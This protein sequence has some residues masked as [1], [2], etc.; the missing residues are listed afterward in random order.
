MA[1][2]ERLVAFAPN[3]RGDGA[4]AVDRKGNI[5]AF[6]TAPEFREVPEPVPWRGGPFVAI[7]STPSG[8]G[9]WILDSKGNLLAYGDATE[10]RS[11][12][13]SDDKSGR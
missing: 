2:R 8:Q 10:L 12:R 7:A 4:W 13:S 9:V 1:R 3:P 11:A 6:G 5:F